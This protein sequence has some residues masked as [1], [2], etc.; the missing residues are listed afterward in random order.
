MPR[1][2]V[3]AI[4]TVFSIAAALAFGQTRG[5]GDMPSRIRAERLQR[6][7]A[8]SLYRALTDDIGARLTG[9]PAHLQSAR[10]ARDRF[11]EWGL[12]NSHLEPFDFGRGWE[13]ERVAV[14]MTEPRYMPLIAYADAWSP[15][16]AGAVVGRTVYIGDKTAAQLES[17][18]DQLRGAVV[19]TH[20]P[21]AEFVEGDR[22]QPGLD[23]RP[24]ATGN[25]TLPGAR[26]GSAVN[27]FAALLRKMGVAVALRPSAYRD[28][29][30]GVTGNP[31]T[32]PMQC[33]RSSSPVSSTTCSPA[34]PSRGVRPRCAW[35]CG[36]ALY[37]GRPEQLQ[38]A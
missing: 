25:P 38:R 8:L 2:L 14:E 35:S 30:V 27:D 26:R 19:L 6:S 32:P 34:S 16:T 3:P 4:V 36:R 12:T 22:P 15:S 7:S 31:S 11:E 10:W 33:R 37:R 29:T 24:V 5:A 17:R 28:G 20:L 21:Q 9:S 23:D 13:L 1:G 18:A